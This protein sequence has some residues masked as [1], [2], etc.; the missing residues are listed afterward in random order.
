MFKE[1]GLYDVDYLELRLSLWPSLWSVF[2][3]VSEC[4][5]S[6]F[7][8]SL[9]CPHFSA[10]CWFHGEVIGRLCADRIYL[11]FLCI[12]HNIN[13]LSSL[14]Y[15]KI[16]IV[17]VCSHITCSVPLVSVLFIFLEGALFSVLRKYIFVIWASLQ[18]VFEVVLEEK[19]FLIV[20]MDL[21]NTL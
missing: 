17:G 8:F 1:F 5:Q 6:M 12:N 16:Q 2:I 13:C 15:S 10:H 19:P 3:N 9:W 4:L 14:S 18:P 11:W 7:T 21:R 20:L